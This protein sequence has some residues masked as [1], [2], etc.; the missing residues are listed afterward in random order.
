MIGLNRNISVENG[1]KLLGER[2]SGTSFLESLLRTHFDLS[3]FDSL[4][5]VT[6]EMTPFAPKGPFPRLP[7]GQ[8][9]HEAMTDH[10]HYEQLPQN[11]GWKHAAPSQ[12]FVDEFLTPKAPAVLIIVRHPA[13]WL[14]SMHRNPFHS[15]MQET[16]DFARFLRQ[17][18]LTVERDGV[19]PRY[20]DSL[21]ALMVLKMKM[22]ADLLANYENSALIRYEDLVQS[23]EETLRILDKQ[24][25]SPIK[26]PDAQEDARG[27]ISSKR[28]FWQRRK[29]RNYRDSA[30]QAS[31]DKLASD[32][33]NF[34]LDTLSDSPL[35]SLYPK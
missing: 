26:T 13:S 31:Y 21:L 9:A 33:R 4:P 15:L 5:I 12:R 17:P 2:N 11:G 1:L 25:L 10:L 29:M 3:L 28:A 19:A 34:V 30:Q 16:P 20:H 8:A 23:P 32:D 27:F 14:K 7:N 22:H 18:W 6:H 24:P 35:L